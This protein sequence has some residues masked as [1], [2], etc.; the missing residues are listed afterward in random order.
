MILWRERAHVWARELLYCEVE[1][2]VWLIGV[3]EGWMGVL[4]GERGAAAMAKAAVFWAS[5]EGVVSA[6]GPSV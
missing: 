3:E 5:G 1:P 2:M 6:L 4:H